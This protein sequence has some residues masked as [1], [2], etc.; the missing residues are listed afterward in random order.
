MQEPN[1]QHA[2]HLAVHG[3]DVE[4]L[5]YPRIPTWWI[6]DEK[7]MTK[8]PLIK[9]ESGPAGPVGDLTWS[10]D[11]RA[12]L[13]RGWIY[14]SDTVRGLA[15]VCGMDGDVFEQTLQRYNAGCASGHDDEFGR[16]SDSLAPICEPPYYAVPLWPGGSHTV[17]GPRR[18]AD[19]QVLSVRGGTIGNLFSAGELGSVY[20]LLYPV[21]GGSL[22]EC[23]AS[24]RVA[25]RAAARAAGAK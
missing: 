7:R 19:C 14:H 18:N 21:G 20:G 25:G 2:A 15:E 1:R 8:A 17:G 6:F 16:P 3:M 23:L 12:E 10:D 13:A 5:A 9:R 11:N 24:G 22:A 4:R